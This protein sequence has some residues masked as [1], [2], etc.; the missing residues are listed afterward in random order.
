MKQMLLVG[1]LALFALGFS[2]CGGKKY[3]PNNDPVTRMYDSLDR[4]D[5][6]RQWGPPKAITFAD[7]DDTADLHE[8]RISIEGY[9]KVG[10]HIYGDSYITIQLW[11]RKNQE[12]GEYVAVSVT[13][14]TGNNEIK[15]LP[16]KYKRSDMAVKD[17]KGQVIRHGDKVRITGMYSRPY[18]DGY[19]SMNAQVIEKIEDTPMDYSTLGA[20]KITTDTAGHAALEGKLVYAEGVLEI[21]SVVYI[22]E[23]VY[24]DLFDR[25]GDSEYLTVDIIIGEGPDMVEDIPKDYTQNDIKIHDH[26]DMIVGAKKVRVYGIW[27]YNRIAAE[28]VEIL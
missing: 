3:D 1:T 8:K 25:K 7:A 26:K 5:S 2:S 21:P 22:D 6:L 12:K 19:G 4:L 27:K 9:L 10:S 28:C 13:V 18:G 23:T 11:E 17:D 16:D 14:G 15:E 20:V 24:F